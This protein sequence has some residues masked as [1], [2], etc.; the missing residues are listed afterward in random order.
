M[1]DLPARVLVLANQKGGVGKTTTAINLGTALGAAHDQPLLDTDNLCP[2]SL[3]VHTHYRADNL[4]GPPA[5]ET[6]GKP[7]SLRFFLG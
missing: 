2:P 4:L 1:S 6:V 3:P 5:Q 7:M